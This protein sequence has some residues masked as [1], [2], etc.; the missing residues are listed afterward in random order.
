MRQRASTLLSDGD[1]ASN[2]GFTGGGLLAGGSPTSQGTPTPASRGRQR[3][4]TL[5]ATPSPSTTEF[6][7]AVPTSG[8]SPRSNA[9][10]SQ[11]LS[12]KP[13]ARILQDPSP[14]RT[15]RISQDPPPR[16]VARPA[17]PDSSK[18]TGT[19]DTPSSRAHRSA[20]K[21][22]SALK[23]STQSSPVASTSSSRQAA[24]D[25]LTTPP[26]KPFAGATYTVALRGNSPASST[27]DSSSGRTPITP[28]DGAE[29][30]AA[31]AAA[32]KR[33][34]RKSSSAALDEA[35][36]GRLALREHDK[37]EASDP[38]ESRRRE[39]RRSEAK[40]AIE[41]SVNVISAAAPILIPRT[42]NLF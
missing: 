29:I 33:G 2:K 3:S 6:P 8:P 15:V 5:V 21:P 27:G 9:R 25:S 31:S 1:F 36:R 32:R 38:E 11:D 20:F 22:K 41:V 18:S 26:P 40:A 28:V 13:N 30:R 17:S 16:L 10:M 42:R 24:L 4:S 37:A 34:H 23:N 19:S 12:T 14:G 39:R 35:S 7:S